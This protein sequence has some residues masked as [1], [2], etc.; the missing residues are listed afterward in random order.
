M[1]KIGHICIR[2]LIKHA[3]TYFEK[4]LGLIAK[5]II[6]ININSIPK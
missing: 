1:R 4:R 6:Q 2:K 5:K 3:G